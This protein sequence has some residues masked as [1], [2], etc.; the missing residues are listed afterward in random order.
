MAVEIN[1]AEPCQEKA[2]LVL[3]YTR[4]FARHLEKRA[5]LLSPADFETPAEYQNTLATAE[6]LDK[7][8][9]EVSLELERH[10]ANHR[11]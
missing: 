2:T 11:C 5:P 1:T 8:T 6:A 4:L 9:N 10:I 3:E 7:A